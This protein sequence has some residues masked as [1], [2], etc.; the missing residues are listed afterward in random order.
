MQDYS[1]R[2]D[3]ALTKAEAYDSITQAEVFLGANKLLTIRSAVGKIL[4]S[5]VIQDTGLGIRILTKD[6]GLGFSST[7]DLSDK[8]ISD[9]IEE[10]FGLARY[11]KVNPDYSFSSSQKA[12][13]VS[14]FYDEKLVDTIFSYEDINEQIN[15]MLQET[16]DLDPAIKEAAGP[17]HLV[18]FSKRILNSNGVNVSEKG[19]Y[20]T[21]ELMAVAE[22]SSDRREGTDSSAGYSINEID[23]QSLSQHAA[24]MAVRSLNGKKIDSASYEI[25]LSPVSV[26]TF[27]GWLAYL[28]FPQYQEKDMPLLRD[29]IGEQ[30]VTTAMTVGH[31]PLRV[32]TPVSGAYDD[33]GVPTRDT[34]LIKDGMFKEIPLDT[35]YATKYQTSSNGMAF[36]LQAGSGMTEYPGQLYQSEP[37][38]L[39]PALYIEGGKNS[40]DEMIEETKNGIYLDFLHYAYI[41]NGST[42]DYTGVLRQGTFLINKGEIIGPI[43]KCRLLDNIIEMAKN[44]E[45]IGPSRMVGH[46]DTFL[47][48]PPVKISQVDIMPY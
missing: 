30:I 4:E 40:I 46:W 23:T 33:E 31:D 48:V 25:I 16:L 10:A 42:G 44:I 26:S 22:S 38:P 17:T 43:Q 3:Y 6:H 36:R 7:S 29:K 5:K 8:S 39:L 28:M 37:A 15:Q 19:T 18:E 32:P 34:V 35:Y 27:L 41:T 14:K 1:E 21:M 2:I 13:R 9:S 45:M 12:N 11:R 20:W 47:E 24:D